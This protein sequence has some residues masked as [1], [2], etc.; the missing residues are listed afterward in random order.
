MELLSRNENMMP[1]SGTQF[2]RAK[3]EASFLPCICALVALGSA[4]RSASLRAAHADCAHPLPFPACQERTVGEQSFVSTPHA[5][6]TLTIYRS[7][8]PMS[9]R[10][11]LPSAAQRRSRMEAGVSAALDAYIVVS[12]KLASRRACNSNETIGKSE[13]KGQKIYNVSSQTIQNTATLE[14]QNQK[15]N[16]F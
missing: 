5:G 13:K 15:Q 11:R 14:E 10:S 6:M 1:R 3:R 12:P 8:A 4:R 2:S 7:H 9:S 16:H